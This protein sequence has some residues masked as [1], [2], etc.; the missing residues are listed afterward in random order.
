MGDS[1]IKGQLKDFAGSRYP[2][3]IMAGLFFLYCVKYALSLN[4]WGD[5]AYTLNTAQQTF[6]QII[7]MK[8]AHSPVYMIFMKMIIAL[9]GSAYS[10]E[11]FIRLIH[12]CFFITALYFGFKS[13]QMLFGEGWLSIGI[14]GFAMLI[15]GY[16][17]Y[18]TNIRVYALLFCFIMWFIWSVLKYIRGN[19]NFSF[20]TDKIILIS[21]FLLIFFDFIGLLY[22]VPGAFLVLNNMRMRKENIGRGIMLLLLPPVLAGLILSPVIISVA[23]NMLTLSA[24][25]M[26]SVDKEAGGIKFILKRLFNSSRP[27]VELTDI[28][29]RN[30]SV[31]LAQLAL[32]GTLLF[33]GTI[34][35]IMETWRRK[36][37]GMLLILAVA[38]LWIITFFTSNSLTRIFLPSQFF[39]AAIIIYTLFQNKALLPLKIAVYILLT[40]FSLLF[41]LFAPFKHFNSIVPYRQIAAEALRTAQERKI[42]TILISK[43]SLN[44]DSVFRYMLQKNKPGG[45]EIGWVN[46]EYRTDEIPDKDF[47]YLSYMGENGKYIDPDKLAD[48]KM[49]RKAVAVENYIELER[50][51]YNSYWKKNI[52]DKAIQK[53]AF[54]MYV[55]RK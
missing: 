5:E 31:P 6:S 27:F 35:L 3:I 44:N 2:F 23:G 7:G 11:I 21:G 20:S 33:L 32:Y 16:V 47:L 30:I 46:P 24:S 25:M 34:N 38:Y 52:S 14:T 8:D 42:G 1:K 26:H 18:A 48:A 51:P 4:L 53:Y 40:G 29:F 37:Q 28:S 36:D 43:T 39:M 54:I 41:M 49:K 22:Y 55:I 17:F 12:V 19:E 13:L 45:I 10:S 9:T 15:P 50:L